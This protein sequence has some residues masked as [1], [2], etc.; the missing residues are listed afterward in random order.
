MTRAKQLSNNFITLFSANVVGQILFFAGTL[1]LARILGPAGYGI[2]SFAQAWQLYL[3]RIGEFGFEVT[4]IREVA[5]HPEHTAKW[6]GTLVVLRLCFAVVLFVVTMIAGL[7]NLIPHGAT[8]AVMLF[9]LAVFPVTFVLEWVYEAR[10][11]VLVTSIARVMKGVIFGIGVLLFV[12]EDA[13]L[14]NSV[15][16]YILSVAIPGAVVF[17]L[18]VSSFGFDISSFSI[19]KGCQ[20][21]RKA[22]SV[23]LANILSHYS[24]FVGTMIVGYVMSETELGLFSAAHRVVVLPWVYV[25]VS[26]QRVLLPALSRWYMET[27]QQYGAFVEGFFRYS[28]I[29]SLAIGLIG[30][31]WGPLFMSTVYSSAY[32]G[33][34]PVFTI[35]LWALV[36]AGMR[37]IF[38]IAL[39]ASDN[40][41]RFLNGMIL[42]ATLYTIATPILSLK[43]GIKGAAW[44]GVVAE[45]SYALFLTATFPHTRFVNLMHQIWKPLVGCILALVAGWSIKPSLI[46]FQGIFSLSIYAGFIL[47]SKAFS[48]REFSALWNLVGKQKTPSAK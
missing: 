41:R 21:I 29:G 6:I 4:G 44:A 2:W 20:V 26:F 37:F 15:F 46:V 42:L 35:L 34:M 1:Y 9:S 16:V 23:G 10:Q 11:N 28:V 47:L 48:R 12:R 33:A 14:T 8:V 45:L 22:T 27:H 17:A 25:F 31:F 39:I 43:F 36:F 40:Q 3:L 18:A 38:E 30:T 24:L 5:R 19:Y 7:S 32:S 13:D